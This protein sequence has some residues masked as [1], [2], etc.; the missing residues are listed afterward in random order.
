MG[1]HE[2]N[3]DVERS[4]QINKCVRGTH[5]AIRG[6]RQENGNAPRAAQAR[7]H[8]WG[9]VMLNPVWPVLEGGEIG[10]ACLVCGAGI[11]IPC[12]D[13]LVVC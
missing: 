11:R 13:E 6:T 9:M 12:A 10:P 4:T 3:V 2:R 7:A 1:T 5:R 8:H